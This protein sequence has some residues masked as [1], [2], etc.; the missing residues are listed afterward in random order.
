MLVSIGSG[1]NAGMFE[2]LRTAKVHYLLARL[3]SK[4]WVAVS[5]P[6]TR[7]FKFC[8]ATRVVMAKLWFVSPSDGV[9]RDA[10][11]VEGKPEVEFPNG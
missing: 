3:L 11:P 8:C 10:A 5:S 6:S 7:F 2:D 4:E 9:V 1:N